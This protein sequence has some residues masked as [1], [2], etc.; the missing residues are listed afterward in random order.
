MTTT[1]V[2]LTDTWVLVSTTAALVQSQG[3]SG[4]YIYIGSVAPTA[5]SPFI[6]LNIG[7]TYTYTPTS[8]SLYARALNRYNTIIGVIK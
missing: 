5:T 4:C 7:D 1:A 8:D 6:V 3:N 2:T